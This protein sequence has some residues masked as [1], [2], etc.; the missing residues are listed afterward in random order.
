MTHTLLTS[1]SRN[2]LKVSKVKGTAD[3]VSQMARV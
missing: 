1:A 2:D 3:A